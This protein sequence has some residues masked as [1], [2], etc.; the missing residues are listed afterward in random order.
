MNTRM[1]FPLLLT[2]ASFSA[3]AGNQAVKNGWCQTMTEDGQALVMLKNGTIGITGLMQGCPKFVTSLAGFSPKQT[4]AI[5]KDSVLQAA[6][7][8]YAREYDEETT[9]TADFGSYEVKGNKV[10]FEVFNPEDRAY[11]KVTVTVGA[12][13]NATGASVEF[14]G[15]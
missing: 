15:K 11:D 9:E 3:S 6:R 8:A 14:I 4:P 12:D 2:V 10:E 7:Q 1:L 13:G 5:N